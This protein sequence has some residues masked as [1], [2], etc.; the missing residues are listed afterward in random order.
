MISLLLNKE[1]LNPLIFNEAYYLSQNEDLQALGLSTKR[2]AKHFLKHG[3]NEGRNSSPVF[4]AGYYLE[5]NPDLAA[6]LGNDPATAAKHFLR[7]GIKENRPT[8][9]H[10]DISHYYRVNKDLH[11]RLG[12]D[13]EKLYH[14]FIEHGQYE[15]R[16]YNSFVMPDSIMIEL[17]NACN[18][19]CDTCPREYEFGSQMEIGSM[20]TEKALE[21]ISE[22]TEF[23]TS[24][25]LTGLGETFLYKNL[26][27]LVDTIGDMD[28]V[29][30]FLSTNGQTANCLEMTEKISDKVDL[31]QISVDGTGSVYEKV[32]HGADFNVFSANVGKMAGIVRDTKTEIML[33]MVTYPQ[34]YDDMKNVVSFAHK[35]GIKRLHI[36]TRNLVTMP[37]ADLTEYRFYKTDQFLNEMQKTRQL[38][39]ELDVAV[40][41]FSAEHA[42]SDYC[43]L[44]LTGY[45]IT[46]NGFLVPCCAK[47]F[48]KELHFGNVFEEGAVSCIQRFQQSEFRSLWEQEK[49]PPFC[50]RCHM[51]NTMKDL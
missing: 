43:D 9:P 38:G 22:V 28:G 36:N 29:T 46:W 32:R 41:T 40:T 47:P 26:E 1:L 48:P 18:L 17:T 42:R 4:N 45:Y 7:K 50:A 24:I 10:F 44:V 49:I 16:R 37:E 6:D 33:N 15:G 20:D 30:S 27:K 19:H 13:Y 5:N 12:R 51:V 2:L 25:N 14:H 8:S 21:L 31:I 3:L 34:N 35:V 11:E 23:A 39:K